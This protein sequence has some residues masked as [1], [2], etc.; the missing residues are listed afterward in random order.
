[1]LKRLSAAERAAI[2]LDQFAT[3][4]RDA[5][6]A[7][8]F[9]IRASII[10]RAF[11]AQVEAGD[12]AGAVKALNIDAPAF[13]PMLDEIARAYVGGG[14]NTI[15]ELPPVRTP[16]GF[17][18]NLRFDA[19]NPTAEAWLRDH[20]ASLVREITEDQ[21]NSIRQALA[22]GQAKG[23][24]G[25]QMASDIIGRI[26]RATGQRSGGLIGLTSTQADWVRAYR[27][28]LEALDPNALKRSLRYPR[29]DASLRKA[30]DA[31][32]PL[33]VDKIDKMVMA[34]ENRA[35]QYRGEAIGRSESL[36]AMNNASGEAMRQTIAAGHV[37]A[38]LVDQK[39]HT[40]MDG[41]ERETHATMNGQIQPWGSSFE[42]GAGV[43]LRYPG[44]EAAPASERVGCRCNRTFIIRK[45]PRQT[46][47]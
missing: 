34:Y 2:F 24:S 32:K 7:A 46:L 13:N 14:N 1:M 12:I 11:I 44:D 6:L 40:I 23:A 42:S 35:L 15:N 37:S 9:D 16:G 10:L 5:F 38:A 45:E 41:R 43:R 47:Q 25:R 17:P 20:S 19:R 39:W 18:I 31:D 28:E 22:I 4:I 36:T 8:I 30:I 29:F 27:A 26:N 21:M 3:A 33:P